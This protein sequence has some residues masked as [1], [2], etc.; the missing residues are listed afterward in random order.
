MHGAGAALRQPAAEMRVVQRQLIAQR[1]E[2]RHVGIGID[3]L[4]LAVHV[5]I[6]SGHGGHVSRR[7]AVRRHA[8]V[9]SK[10]HWSELFEFSEDRLPPWI[11]K[12]SL[13]TNYFH[14]HVNYF[15]DNRSVAERA[16]RR[17]LLS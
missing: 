16:C 6:C 3:R 11:S 1:V 2:Q 4:D 10:P 12:L 8:A 9:P 7:D 5:E 17:S 15:Y 13:N 14:D